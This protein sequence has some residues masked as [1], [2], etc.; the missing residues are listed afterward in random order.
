VVGR[1]TEREVLM[2]VG[3]TVGRE[4]G[5]TDVLTSDGQIGERSGWSSAVTAGG[6]PRDGR[7]SQRLL[8]PRMVI[9]MVTVFPLATLTQLKF[10]RF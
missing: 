8:A 6:R 7:R 5:T 9:G 4:D 1:T 2:D 10:S 3:S